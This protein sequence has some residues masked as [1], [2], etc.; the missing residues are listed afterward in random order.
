MPLT[1]SGT[2]VVAGD[3]AGSAGSMLTC[4]Q[5]LSANASLTMLMLPLSITIAGMASLRPRSCKSSHAHPYG[6]Y[7]ARC[8][9]LVV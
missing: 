4:M 5:A 2:T 1:V 8:V 9:S 7:M 6:V 3:Q